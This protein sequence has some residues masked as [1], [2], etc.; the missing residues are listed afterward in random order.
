MCGSGVRPWSANRGRASKIG[1]AATPLAK[2]AKARPRRQ[3]PGYS[4]GFEV[5]AVS[6]PSQNAA[7]S[8]MSA[9]RFAKASLR[10]YA[11]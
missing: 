1:V 3:K 11:S 9:R 6:S 7:H 5:A 8:F 2:T 4:S 10:R